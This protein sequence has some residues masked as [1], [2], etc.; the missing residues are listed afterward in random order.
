M[1]PNEM[2]KPLGKRLKHL[3]R[4]ST[5]VDPLIEPALLKRGFAINRLVSHWQDIVGD[6]AMWCRPARISFPKGSRRDGTLKVQIA[7]GYGPQAQAM[8]AEIINLVNTA[9][10]YRAICRITL[11]Q[12]L[13]TD[14][15][16]QPAFAPP[17]ISDTPDIWS[18]DEKLKHVKSPP[19]R[20]A[21]RRL[22]APVNASQDPN[23][24][25]RF[26]TF[27]DDPYDKLS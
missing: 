15:G 12:S 20:A 2:R 8:S 7:S 22:G 21:L 4:L 18:L 17:Q 6:I 14:G 11:M 16:R 5:M 13:P 25:S 1:K 3:R 26:D 23:E 24:N 27:K 10:G 9:F 19:L